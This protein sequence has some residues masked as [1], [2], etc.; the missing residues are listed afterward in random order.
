M[1]KAYD[2]KAL[3]ELVVAEMKK[4]GLAVAEEATEKLARAAYVGLK[5][6]LTDS[7]ALS[8][9]KIDDLLAPL[10]TVVDGLVLPQIAKIDL[11]GDGK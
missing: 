11:D 9:N 3:G 8:E 10:L 1:E 4:D 2:L 6:W 5:V 7:S